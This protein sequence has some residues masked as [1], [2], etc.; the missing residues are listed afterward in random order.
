V[1]AASKCT[2]FW[3]PAHG[4]RL[5]SNNETVSSKIM[6]YELGDDVDVCYMIYF[7]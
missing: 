5:L 2:S 4:P 7:I 1:A 3:C 6:C